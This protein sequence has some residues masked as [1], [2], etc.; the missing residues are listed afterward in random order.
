MASDDVK[1]L[2]LKCSNED[3]GE[4]YY[5]NLRKH[6]TQECA[7]HFFTYVHNYPTPVEL[8]VM[9]VPQKKKQKKK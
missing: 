3:M 7:N 6:F 9:P 1:F 5:E 8:D 2:F 4:E